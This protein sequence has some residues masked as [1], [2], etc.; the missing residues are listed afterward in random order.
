M[1]L[2]K[3]KSN[4]DLTVATFYHID[5]PKKIQSSESFFGKQAK[6][7]DQEYINRIHKERIK[8]KDAQLLGKSLYTCNE[9]GQSLYI[10]GSKNKVYHFAHPD[11]KENNCPQKTKQMSWKEIQRS[12]KPEGQRHKEIKRLIKNYLLKNEIYKRQIHN[13][14]S[15]K[16]EYD[17]RKEKYRIPDVKATF[18]KNV[19]EYRVAFELQLSTTFATVIAEREKFYFDNKIFLLWI[20]SFLY[21]DK[22]SPKNEEEFLKSEL[23]SRFTNKDIYYRKYMNIFEINEESD[24]LSEEQNDL[25]LNCWYYTGRRWV[26]EYV[27]LDQLTFEEEN[28]VL[29]YKKPK[30]K[31]EVE[32]EDLEQKLKEEEEEKRAFINADN[33]R[34]KE[35]I[36]KKR[37]VI[38]GEKRKKEALYMFEVELKETI[39]GV[40]N[41]NTS[42]TLPHLERLLASNTEFC[43]IIQKK[44]NQKCL[45]K[46]GC[47]ISTYFIKKYYNPAKANYYMLDMFK[48]LI[49]NR[50]FS[51]EIVS[52]DSKSLVSILYSKI[53]T[54][55]I[56]TINTSF[57]DAFLNLLINLN[58]HTFYSTNE[59]KFS[60]FILLCKIKNRVKCTKVTESVNRL[61]SLYKVESNKNSNLLNLFT[62]NR[63]YKY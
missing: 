7:T 37:K 21:A 14:E 58:Y 15:E 43:T 55:N 50:V 48:V 11:D 19:K 22:E 25:V 5:N 54:S 46:N 61:I 59:N 18:T 24:K 49:D 20:F 4:R 38:E 39:Q 27:T 52:N 31:E 6:E 42:P 35:L 1:K 29:Y 47:F 63:I 36:D 44:Y 3:D 13:V 16:R 40:D 26:S 33:A 9:C 8:I 53:I 51:I 62:N 45:N 32:K 23:Y 57:V 17:P 56:F 34:K 30:S 2:N 12:K 28:N 60:D 10:R 41:I